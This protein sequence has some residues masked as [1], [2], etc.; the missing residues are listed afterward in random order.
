MD[1]Q[2]RVDVLDRR[3]VHAVGVRL[4]A[5]LGGQTLLEAPGV[6]LEHVDVIGLDGDPAPRR[7]VQQNSNRQ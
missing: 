7:D 4:E 1:R 6:R 2:Q 3:V 5:Q